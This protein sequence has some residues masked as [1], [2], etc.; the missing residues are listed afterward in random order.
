MDH[1]QVRK[2]CIF[3]AK[4]VR[5]P[6]MAFGHLT[7]C[8]VVTG[9]VPPSH[10]S[11]FLQVAL[12][13]QEL[14]CFAYRKQDPEAAHLPPRGSNGRSWSYRAGLRNVGSALSVWSSNTK[15]R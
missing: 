13:T 11:S 10:D 8:Q 6:D 15:G 1:G 3:Q 4:P 9:V 2:P 12:V 14:P 7:V 5:W